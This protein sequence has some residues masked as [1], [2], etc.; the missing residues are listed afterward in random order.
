MTLKRYVEFI[1]FVVVGM[2]LQSLFSTVQQLEE[3]QI[4]EWNTKTIDE[5][6]KAAAVQQ[7]ITS[8]LMGWPDPPDDFTVDMDVDS[9]PDATLRDDAIEIYRSV[10]GLRQ[11]TE[12]QRD[13]VVIQ[14]GERREKINL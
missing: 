12:T 3:T 1:A 4:R 14:T 6:G 9:K 7:E 13:R 11:I 2:A 8:L 5:L 10:K